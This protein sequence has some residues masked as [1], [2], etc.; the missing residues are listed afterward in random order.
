MVT[1][2]WKPS[3]NDQ[4]FGVTKF[5]SNQDGFWPTKVAAPSEEPVGWLMPFGNGFASRPGM[6]VRPLST[7]L[8]ILVLVL[9]PDVRKKSLVGFE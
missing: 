4:T 7:E 6:Y 1:W 3:E 8:L 2:N 9:N 5:G